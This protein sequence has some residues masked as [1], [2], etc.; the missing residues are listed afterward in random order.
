[1]PPSP[2]RGPH[3]YP[4]VRQRRG[5]A[6]CRYAGVYPFNADARPRAGV[7]EVWIWTY[8]RSPTSVASTASAMTHPL[9]T[10]AHRGPSISNTYAGK[11]LSLS[12]YVPQAR[13]PASAR[14][15][16]C[17]LSTCLSTSSTGIYGRIRQREE[18]RPDH[19]RDSDAG[20]QAR[21][22]RKRNKRPVPAL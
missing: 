2:Q 4:E 13:L 9:P 20:G 22:V 14:R 16:T 8:P 21:Q 19:D 12:Y 15:L 18:W 6:G 7:N 17:L 5:D 1:M 10:D 11:K 3:R